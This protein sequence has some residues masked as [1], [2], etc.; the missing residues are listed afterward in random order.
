MK[1][2][3]VIIFILVLAIAYVFLLGSFLKVLAVGMGVTVP[4]SKYYQ[5]INKCESN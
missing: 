2:K 5:C 1:N 3:P 4:E